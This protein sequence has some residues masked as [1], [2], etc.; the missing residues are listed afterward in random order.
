MPKN[1][2]MHYPNDIKGVTKG[3][4]T[5]VPNGDKGAYGDYTTKAIDKGSTGDRPRQ[6]V[7]NQRDP[8]S[9]EYPKPIK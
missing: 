9:W 5:H 1:V 2:G 4:P 6:G 8:Y 7:T 3:Y